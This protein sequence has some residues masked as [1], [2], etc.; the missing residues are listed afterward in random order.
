M[1]RARLD[2]DRASHIDVPWPGGESYRDVVERTRTF[3]SDVA[4]RHDGQRIL[5]V[6]HSA[7]R[8]ALDHLLRGRALHALIDE[9]FEWQPGWEY[10]VG[11]A[12]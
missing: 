4:A 12:E 7:N 5:V 9:P 8:L 2:A 3:L 11:L 1:P 6:A 10:E